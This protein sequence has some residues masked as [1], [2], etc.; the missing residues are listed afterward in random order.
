MSS[1]RA[2]WTTRVPP[3]LGR[4]EYT[5]EPR[6][7]LGVEWPCRVKPSSRNQALDHLRRQRM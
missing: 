6:R 4:Y 3:M 7:Q 1:A 2:S 5:R